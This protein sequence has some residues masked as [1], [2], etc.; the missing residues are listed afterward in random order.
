MYFWD[1]KKQEA[2]EK[3]PNCQANFVL[4]R[5]ANCSSSCPAKKLEIKHRKIVSKIIKFCLGK[6]K[7]KIEH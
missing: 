4:G 1:E 7:V 6:Q 2:V 5:G 3:C